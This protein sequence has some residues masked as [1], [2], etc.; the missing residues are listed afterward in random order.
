MKPILQLLAL[1]LLCSCKYVMYHPDEVRPA[2]KDLNARNIAKLA[3][4]PSH[5]SFK[6]VLIGDTQ[7]FYEELDAFV[8]HINIQNDITFVL[9]NGD[10]VD[11]GL[12]REYNWIAS[13]LDKLNVP[14]IVA[15]GN[16]DMLANGQLIFN[17]MFG[18]E[19]FTF[20]YG[21]NK[22]IC[23]NTNSRE[24]GNDGTVPNLS[25]LQ[26]ELEDTTDQNI[27]IL[28]HV[29]PFSVDFDQRMEDI[30]AATI[31]ANPRTR[32][33][34]HGHEHHYAV[35]RPYPDQLEYV[36]AAAGNNRSYALI[37]ITGEDCSVDQKYY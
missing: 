6:F 16:H 11:F 24:S 27:F 18:P 9:F 37:T 14:Y 17:E 20:N 3:S 32:M 28:S 12:N 23:L 36:V 2:E 8:N 31:S 4:L 30:F 25:F 7:R 15:M 35:L 26:N 5:S 22:F 29:P 13:R 34:L 1:S 33:S 10:M 19:N 21:N